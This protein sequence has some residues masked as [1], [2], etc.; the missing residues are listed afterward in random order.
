MEPWTKVTLIPGGFFLNLYHNPTY[1]KEISNHEDMAW[2]SQKGFYVH[3]SA[4]IYWVP[5]LCP[6]YLIHICEVIINKEFNF[7]SG[8]KM[9]EN[10]TLALHW[11]TKGTQSI[12]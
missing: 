1:E 11:I 2:I 12:G 9:K 10:K 6:A 4:I 3:L 5:A 7:Y 8:K